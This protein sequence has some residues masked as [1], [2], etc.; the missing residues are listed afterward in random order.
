MSKKGDC[1]DNAAMENWNYSFKAEVVHGERFL[2]HADAKSDVFKYIEVY[3]NPN[4]LRTIWAILVSEAQEA[5]K[6]V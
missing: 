5:K 3:Y 6:V 2:T 4:R 1:Y